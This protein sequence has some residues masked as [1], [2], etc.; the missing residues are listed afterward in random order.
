VL[1]AVKSAEHFYFD[2]DIYHT[3][4]NLRKKGETSNIGYI[5]E[6]MELL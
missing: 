1:R 3:T 4:F 5:F 6:I 2:K